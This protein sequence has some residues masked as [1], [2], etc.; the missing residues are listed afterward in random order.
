MRKALLLMITVGILMS[1]SFA[2]LAA[3]AGGVDGKAGASSSP[4]VDVG[5]KICPVSGEKI[6]SMEG[7]PVKVEYKGKSYNLCCPMCA[8]EFKKHPE[9]YVK[10]VNKELEANKK[11]IYKIPPV[12]EDGREP[13]R[14]G[15]NATNRI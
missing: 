2:P 1:L 14:S 7:E 8:A 12:S 15:V 13:R 3:G 11:K 6:G 10:Q 4:A 9:K 5:N